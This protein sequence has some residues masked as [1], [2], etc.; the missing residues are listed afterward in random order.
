MWTV[1]IFEDESNTSK[2]D[3]RENG[4]KIEFGKCLQPFSPE[5]F[6]LLV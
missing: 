3:S 5:P 1:K 4:E 2:F 6:Y